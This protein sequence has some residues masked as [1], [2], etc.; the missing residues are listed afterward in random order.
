VAYS[1]L[2]FLPW[3][4]VGDVTAVEPRRPTEPPLSASAP[5]EARHVLQ[6]FFDW[7][8]FNDTLGLEPREEVVVSGV[9]DEVIVKRNRK[10]V[11][12]MS[13]DAAKSSGVRWFH[14]AG[15]EVERDEATL[16]VTTAQG[17]ARIDLRRMSRGWTVTGGELRID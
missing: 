13:R 17:R 16:L 15:M 2:L 6:A 11:R 9:G 12:I 4:A 5:A 10:R 1:R 3:L 7:P 14:V 8:R